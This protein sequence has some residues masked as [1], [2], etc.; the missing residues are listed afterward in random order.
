MHDDQS[1]LSQEVLGR[2]GVRVLTTVVRAV[3]EGVA[4]AQVAAGTFLRVA[5]DNGLAEL[6]VTVE[7][8]RWLLEHD[9]EYATRQAG[10]GRGVWAELGQYVENRVSLGQAVLGFCEPCGTKHS[11]HAHDAVGQV[12]AGYVK[13]PRC[14]V[15]TTAAYLDAHINAHD[16]AD[17]GAEVLEFRCQPIGCDAGQHLPGCL[18]A[19]L[20]DHEDGPATLGGYGELGTGK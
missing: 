19:A 11:L 17:V 8:A 12:P 14:P 5:V 4:N 1:P 3:D 13:C 2:E 16:V 10:D 15:L 20:Q 18:H 9:P 6:R 7:G